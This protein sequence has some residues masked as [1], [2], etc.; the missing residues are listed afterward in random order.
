MTPPASTIG[1]LTGSRLE[2][3]CLGRRAGLLIACSGAD[4]GRARDRAG[5]LVEQGALV[6]VS[7]GLAGALDPA[8]RPGDLLLPEAVIRPPS[9]EPPRPPVVNV[10]LAW[11][12]VLHAR[13]TRAGL[14]PIVRPV[15]GS[16]RLIGSPADKARLF[17]TTGAVA[18]DMESHI[19]A[20]AASAA[21]L[22]WLVLRAVA[23]PADL[24]VPGFLARSLRADGKVR[25]TAI[26][27]GLVRQ[28]GALP[29]LLRLHR[30][31]RPALQVLARSAALLFG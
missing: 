30:H 28:P 25:F 22:P 29:S 13:L 31:S 23:D 26:L 11:Q 7:F 27:T 18:V 24:E 17:R 2:A 6:L 1:V 21:G 5:R 8:L 16:D 4:P 3:R 12:A 14:P 15:A 19:V 9:G 20:R 10:A